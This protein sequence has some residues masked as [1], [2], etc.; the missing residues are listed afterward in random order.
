MGVE[1][2][3]VVVNNESLELSSENTYINDEAAE[4]DEFDCSDEI[5]DTDNSSTLN[6]IF[7]L[8]DNLN[9]ADENTYSSSSLNNIFT[10][11]D[12]LNQVFGVIK[13]HNSIPTSLREV[14]IVFREDNISRIL[15]VFS[16]AYVDAL[17]DIA[18]YGKRKPSFSNEEIERIV[19]SYSSVAQNLDKDAI[20]SFINICKDGSV[21]SVVS[22]YIKK[23][24][25]RSKRNSNTVGVQNINFKFNVDKFRELHSGITPDDMTF[26]RTGNETY[27]VI[28]NYARVFW[29]L[30]MLLVFHKVCEITQDNELKFFRIF[31][32]YIRLVL[33][34]GMKMFM[35]LELDCCYGELYE[36]LKGFKPYNPDYLFVEDIPDKQQIHFSIKNSDFLTEAYRKEYNYAVSI[37][38]EYDNPLKTDKHVDIEFC[39]M[40]G[41]NNTSAMIE[42]MISGQNPLGRIYHGETNPKAVVNFQNSFNYDFVTPNALIFLLRTVLNYSKDESKTSYYTELFK[43]L[44]RYKGSKKHNIVP[45]LLSVILPILHQR[46]NE[47]K[48]REILNK[49]FKPTDKVLKAEYRKFFEELN[50]VLKQKKIKVIDRFRMEIKDYVW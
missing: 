43:Y 27:L 42:V 26:D 15:S 34:A 16:I 21:N 25:A 23:A 44:Q 11:E 35:H 17:S 29:E 28:D 37:P 14:S 49:Y 3:R 41:L 47:E 8:V 39:I 40:K 19:S 20:A 18:K 1:K 13:N 22:Y 50:M 2:W 12:N 9:Q 10:V 46:S 33:I 30:Y 31:C 5:K 45:K 24:N 4:F 32:N 48:L 38:Y 36:E 6:N 7:P